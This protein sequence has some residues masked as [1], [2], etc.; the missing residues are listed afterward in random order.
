MKNGK[1]TRENR[2]AYQKKKIKEYNETHTGIFI[3]KELNK[4]LKEYAKNC[5]VTKQTIATQFIQYGLDNL[6][7]KQSITVQENIIIAPPIIERQY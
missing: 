2:L 4:K 6:T 7:V 1:Q 5:H 3:P